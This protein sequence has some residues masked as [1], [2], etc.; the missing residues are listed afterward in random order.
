[1]AHARFCY[2]EHDYKSRNLYLSKIELLL[3]SGIA[4]N[5][6]SQDLRK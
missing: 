1:M 2:S 3:G 6:N 4:I 5:D